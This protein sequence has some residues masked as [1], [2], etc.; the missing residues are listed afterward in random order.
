MALTVAGPVGC[1]Q[2]SEGG[3][4][5]EGKV[6]FGLIDGGTGWCLN[7]GKYSL[8]ACAIRSLWRMPRRCFFD[9]SSDNVVPASVRLA[10]RI[11]NRRAD[12]QR[13]VD[14]VAQLNGGCGRAA[15]MSHRDG[16]DISAGSA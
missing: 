14:G 8:T 7:S 2:G 6:R 4:R 16:N 13:L 12:Q 15:Q 5:R 9:G 3:G 11:L 1:K 10:L